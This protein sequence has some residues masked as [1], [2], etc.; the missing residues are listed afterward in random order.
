MAA[1]GVKPRPLGQ[2]PYVCFRQ[3]RTSA[4]LVLGSNVPIPD[5]S[6]CSKLSKLLLDHLVG[7]GEQRVWHR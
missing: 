3:Q 2:R 4:A 5:L 6:R 7:A 1:N